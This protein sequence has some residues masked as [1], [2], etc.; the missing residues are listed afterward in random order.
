MNSLQIEITQTLL[1]PD[2]IKV[3]L[4]NEN[5]PIPEAE[6]EV[7]LP[8]A[9]D[10][11]LPIILKVL[12]KPSHY[13]AELFSDQE[14]KWLIENRFLREHRGNYFYTGDIQKMVGENLYNTLIGEN[15]RLPFNDAMEH[16]K[17]E[18]N[19]LHLEIRFPQEAGLVCSYPWEL[20]FD[21]VDFLCRGGTCLLTRYIMEGRNPPPTRK[22]TDKLK[23]LFISPRPNTPDVAELNQKEPDTVRHVFEQFEWNESVEVETLQP[24]TL[25]QLNT[26]LQKDRGEG[27]PHI[28]HFDG[29]GVT[30][31]RC[32]NCH[33]VEISPE[34]E[35]CQQCGSP[36]G[37]PHQT[38]QGYLV[39]EGENRESVYIS[40]QDLAEQIRMAMV[41]SNRADGLSEPLCLAVLS[42]CESGTACQGG[43]VFNGV[44]QSLIHARIP[45][46][47]A[48]QFGVTEMD[49]LEFVNTLYENIAD[50]QPLVKAVL[51]GRSRLLLSRNDQWYRPVLYMCWRDH[52]GGRLFDIG[53]A[54]RYPGGPDYFVQ[55]TKQLE[56][57]EEISRIAVDQSAVVKDFVKMLVPEWRKNI[58]WRILLLEGKENTG[59]STV[60]KRFE[61]CCKTVQK[62]IPLLYAPMR[63]EEKVAASLRDIATDIVQK[64]ITSSEDLP[65]L[66]SNTEKLKRLLDDLN[67]PAQSS[68]GPGSN[69]QDSQVFG[70]EFYKRLN[71]ASQGL[72]VILLFDNYDALFPVETG[73]GLLSFLREMA[74]G[75]KQLPNC[76]FA[77]VT[78]AKSLHA[79]P[80][81]ITNREKILDITGLRNAKYHQAISQIGVEDVQ[82]LAER[83]FEF[84]IQDPDKAKQLIEAAKVNG[85]INIQILRNLLGSPLMRQAL[86]GG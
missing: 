51:S 54:M 48:M 43:S 68:K 12:E 57:D 75:I 38:S 56:K 60:L 6:Q 74:E 18:E 46:V 32:P 30:G 37:D 47:I 13:V 11:A 77:A 73:P 82:E 79:V 86:V 78:S 55:R 76:I 1:E 45:A 70:K 61:W 36:L 64:L 9:N 50:S 24:A 28:I 3:C 44:A 62:S 63:L 58:A 40:G 71:E 2:K 52:E 59:K 80:C 34:R 49:A 72:T 85:V 25:H 27:M 42:A 53:P 14:K 81:D 19:A 15:I 65:V 29:H 10:F 8:W 67:N 26:Y 22:V 33:Q 84:K 83:E 41:V 39:F 16:A 20:L 31:R 66:Q 69:I 17:K 5:G 4:S 35:D 7:T 21:G 23:I